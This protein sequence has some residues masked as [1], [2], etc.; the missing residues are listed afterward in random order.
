MSNIEL[1]KAAN[2]NQFT[3]SAT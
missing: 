1:F 3:F 2:A